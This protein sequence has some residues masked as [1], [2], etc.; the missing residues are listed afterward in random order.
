[1]AVY[2]DKELCKSCSICVNACPRQVFKI[3]EHVNKKGYNYV[4]AEKEEDCISCGICESI[5]PDFV[6]HIEKTEN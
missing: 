4:E 1:M 5:C 3:T 2:V 6:I